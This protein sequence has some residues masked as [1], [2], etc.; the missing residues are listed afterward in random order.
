VGGEGVARG[1]LGRPRLTAE[2]FVP[3]PF[4]AAAAGARLYRTGDRVRWT[5]DGVLEFLG[6]ADHQVKIRGFRVE[7]GEVEAALRNHP[8]VAECA[9]VVREDAPGDRRLVAYVVGGVETAELRDALRTRLPEYMVPSA[10]VALEALPLTPSGKVDRRALPQPERSGDEAGYVAPRTPVEEA[11]AGIWAEVLRLERVG[12]HDDFFSLGGH[13]LLIMR[14]VSRAREVFG[15]ELPVRTLFEAP[16]IDRLAR[17]FPEPSVHAAGR[18]A[19]PGARH[20][21]PVVDDLTDDELDRLLDGRFREPEH[22]G[23]VAG[24]SRGEKQALLREVMA[25]R[26]RRTRTEPTSFAQERL[27]FLDRL[28]PG[29]TSYNFPLAWRLGGALD[30]RALERALGEIVRRH[31]PLRTTFV[32]RDGVPVQVVAPFGGFSLPVRERFAEGEAEREAVARRWVAE[33]AA[34]PFDLEAGPLF[35]AELLRLAED[36][37]VLLISMHHVVTDEWSMGVLFR[38][39]AALYEAYREGRG[40]PLAELPAQYADF[41]VWQRE[42]WGESEARHLAYWRERLA[43]A[44]ALLELPIDHPRQLVQS[45]H[46]AY[47]RAELPAALLD[48]LRGLGQREGATLYMVLLAAFQLLLSKYSGSDDVVVGSSIAG[49]TRREVEEMIGFFVNTLVLRTDLSGDPGFRELLA[50]VRE[51]TLGAFEHQDVPFERL[52]A[53]LQPE[54]SLGHSPLFQVMFSLRDKDASGPGLAGLELRPVAV[55]MGTAKFD[56]NLIFVEQAGGLSAVLAYRT[57]LF[58]RSTVERMLGHLSR[59]LEQIA[60]NAELRLS[61]LRLLGEEERHRALVEWNATET[62]YPAGLCIHQLFEAQAERTPDAEAIIFEGARLTYAGLNARANRLAHHL[63]SL[64]VGPDA[65]VGICVERSLELVIGL[66]AL[67]KAGGAYVAL[68]PEHP[69]ERLRTILEDSRPAVLLADSSLAGRFAGTGVPVVAVDADTPLWAGWPETNPAGV[70]VGPEHLVYVI[71]TSGSTGKPKGVLN[72]HRNVVNRVSGIQERWRLEAGE[73]VLQNASLTFDVSAY[74]IFWPLMVGGRVV[75]M[76]PDGHR[77]PSYLV[78]TIRSHG[79]GTASF[80]PSML[81]LFLEH[82]EVESCESLVRVPCGGEALPVALVR[83]LHERLPRATLYNRYGPSEAA[84]AVTGP[85]RVTDEA[86]AS[87]PIGRPMPNAR[88]YLLDRTGEPVPVGVAGELCIGGAGVGRGYLGRSGLTAERFVPDPFGAE[89]GARLYRT[90]DLARWLPDGSIEFL[91]RNDFQ[92]KI[93]GFR[94]EPGE[95]EARLREHAAVREV[96][97]VA[98]EDTPGDTRLVAYYAGGAVEAAALRAHLS[99]RVPEYMVPAAWVRLDALPLTPSGKL[100]R[101]ALPAPE[102][103]AAAG[104]AF[105]APAGEVEETLARIWAEVLGVDRVGRWDHFF[106]LGGHSLLATRVVSRARTAFGVTLAVRAL[107]EAPTLEA[108]ARAVDTARAAGTQAQAAIPRVA[109]D[110]K[111]PLSFPQQRLWLMDRLHPGLPLYNIWAALRLRGVLD[112]DALAEALTALVRRHE[113]L[114]TVFG[115]E[116]GEPV[117]RILPAG[118]V[119]LPLRDLSALPEARGDAAMRERMQR[120]AE[121]PF[122]LQRGPLFRAELLRTGHDEHVLLLGMHHIVA[123]AWSKGILFRELSALY[124]AIREGRKA[125][126]PELAV[127]YADYSAWQRETLAGEWLAREVAWWR[128]Q[129]AGAPALLALPTDRP[130]PAVQSYRGALHPFTLSAPLAEALE[131]LALREGASLYMVLLAGFQVL[132]SRYGGQDEVVVGSPIDNRSRTELDGL[133]GFFV[134]TIALRADL[135]GDPGFREV[136]RRVRETTLDAYAHQEVPFEKLVE[137]LQPERSLG[138]NP[139]FQ[140]FFS[141]QNGSARELGLPGVEV[142]SLAVESSTSKFDLALFVAPHEGRLQGALQYA[143]DLFEPATVARIAAGLE[144]LLQAVAADPERPLSAIPLTTA[145]ERETILARWS[146]AGERFPVTGALHHRF[147]ARAA[148]HPDAPAVACDGASLTWGA[149]NARANRLA[150][151]L[152]AEGVAPES[153]VGLCAERSLDLVVG[154]LAILKAGGAYVPLDPAYPAERL[155]YMA[156]D[157]GLRVV[158]AQ[159]ALRDRVPD[160][161]GVVALEDVPL[162]EMSQ[163]PGVPVDPS[164]L[165]YVIY[166][167]G[168]TGRPK[169]VG[170]THGNVLRLFDSMQ[171]SFAFGER[172]VWTLFHSYAFDFSVWEIWGALLHGGRLV[173]V[174]FDVSRDPAAFRELLRRERVTVLNQTPSAFHALARADE[175]APEPLEHLRMVVFGGEALQYESLRGWLD[176]YGPRQPRLVNMYGITE[177]T[178]HVTWH[179]VTGAELRQ[180]HVGSGVGVPI[181]DLRAYVLDPTGSPAPV[182]IAGELYV[183]GA[184]LARGYLGRPELTARRFVPDP[185]SGDA[186]ARLYR[187]GDLARWKAD[188]TLEYLGRIDQQVKIR[189]HR[190]ELGEIESQLLAQPGVAAAAVIVRG[191]GADA[192]LVGYVVPSGEAPSPSALRDALRRRLPEY[193]VPAAFVALDRIPLTANGKLDRRA[194]PTPDASAAGADDA[195]A[196][197]ATPVAG[198][199]A[200]IWAEVL[201]LERVGVHDDFFELG[202]HSLRATQA[203]ARIREVF[204][205]EMPLR[206]LFEA[207]TVAELAERVEGLRR[208]GGRALPPVVAVDRDRPLPLSF[209]QERMWFLN[210]LQ[211]ETATYNHPVA[212]RLSGA[213]DVPALERALGEVVRRQQVL[214]T[215]LPEQDGRPVQVVTPFSGFVLPVEELSGIEEP[216]REA[217]AKRRLLAEASRPFDLSAG[218][219]FRARLLRLGEAEHVL[220]LLMHHVVTDGWSTGVLLRELSVLYEAYREGGESPLAEPAVQYADYAV[221]QREQLRGEVLEER[222][223]Y[224]RRQLSGAPELLELPTDRPRPAVQDNRGAYAR[225]ELP[226]VLVERLRGVCR[227]EGATLYMVL[228][229]GFQVLLSKYSGSEDVVVGSPIAGRTS[230]EVEELVGFFVNTLVLRTDL[231]GDPTVGEL[232]ARVREATLGAYEHQDVPFER[233]VE[234]LRPERSLSHTPLFQ[235]MF[236]LQN[237][238]SA[239]AG[240]GGLRTEGME[241]GLELAKFDLSLTLREHAGGI[242]GVLGYGTELFE[243]STIERMLGHLTRVLEQ[244]AGNAELRLSQVSLAG[245]EERRVV[246]EAW[247]GT[248]RSYAATPV[249]ALFAGHAR[250]APDAAALLHGGESVSYAALDR[251]ADA[252]ARRLRALGVG[253]E[254]RVGVCMD[255]TPEL[256]TA[257][258]GIWKAGGA[259]VP[260][261]PGYP[262]ER[263]GWIVADAALPVVVTAGSAGDALPEHAAALVRVEDVADDGPGG[264][265]EVPVWASTLAYVIYTSGST[266]RPKGVVVQHGSLA[267]LLAATRE[268]FG[269]GAG[270]VMPALASHAF[271]IWLFEA[272][273]PLSSGAAVRL[274][275]RE[276]VLDVPALLDEACDATLLHAVPAL[277][278]EIAQVERERPRLRRLRRAFVGGDRVPADLLAQMRIA[279]PG[280]ETHILY[281]PTEGTILASTHPVAADRSVEGHPI[282]S[283]LGNVRLYVCDAAGTPQPVG[284][285]GE[286]LIGGAGVARGYLGRP[287]LTADRFVPDPFSAHSGARLYRTG[288]RVRWRADGR[289]EFQ[290]RVDQQVK[291]RGFRIEPGEVEAVLGEHPAVRDCVVV[292]REDVPGELRLVAYL[293][294]EE[295][296]LA[297]VRE[298]LKA[299]VPE[300]MVPSAFV[301]LDRLPLTPN[302]KLDRRALPSPEPAA[303]AVCLPPRNDVETRVAEA[304]GEV[305]G[306]SGI[307]VHDNFFDLGGSSLLLYRV[308]SRLRELRADLRV[309]DLFRYTTIEALAAYLGAQA[310]SDT[311][312]LAQSRSRAEERRAARQRVVRGG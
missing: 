40:S 191:E 108:L 55:G 282:G 207:P 126:L 153:R 159:S 225:V 310:P 307:G 308:Y 118:P 214:R 187:S 257:V 204:G 34:R 124:G 49:R 235:V 209:G 264:A 160:G 184:G 201:R 5:A 196:A 97:V 289:L 276:R 71:Y 131:A 29:N 222:L 231:S 20:L 208:A 15:A 309:V 266:G 220:Q 237:T 296:D 290:G 136:L 58:E 294:A 72:V 154:V 88:A 194:L 122:D 42:Q 203:V 243:R 252:L 299:K 297:A 82:P 280:A 166:T 48:R 36:E 305:L 74:E 279:F 162:D 270:D 188:G 53:E 24:L 33:A 234:E 301:V 144:V 247:N 51:T 96:A 7:P 278:R 248:A 226:G 86:N 60:E 211:P 182:G 260:L 286:L 180:A 94:I 54:R 215:V 113:P 277:M 292:A 99:A 127:Q 145:E 12:V 156:E 75:M 169:G 45:S 100:D 26:T 147:E 78:E 87:A 66:L 197:P 70:G 44:P 8:G 262:A 56:L 30:A 115:E 107:F 250:R 199:L 43:G 206:A 178:V 32:D 241:A 198:V 274:A 192:A 242:R 245:A 150:R 106:A 114:R 98:R 23:A 212:L 47:E 167:S 61:E 41:A 101:K 267:N 3:D 224:W 89:P 193:M 251:R 174:P 129:L 304:W 273:L 90:G 102:G 149:L 110:G 170:V 186:G 22:A 132:L 253:P 272:L 85:V 171:S 120:W 14:V 200:G 28:Q 50:R 57:E 240:L 69:D 261:D 181:P 298:A 111:V 177:T 157:S 35:R 295:G 135:G 258:L 137:E 151:Q 4:A 2:R 10:V 228:L 233:L 249:H 281:G 300:H 16:T 143:T 239:P 18:S 128:A 52:V 205:V 213:L 189:G 165:A 21:G 283:P 39:L 65:R 130:R 221:W 163:D 219:L 269:V 92:V 13:S 259:Y 38:E 11:L 190:I 119:A 230:R 255:R 146:G 291:I 138:H 59:V 210:R 77:D 268:A 161:V 179:T 140:A 155:A 76:R 246:L 271:D 287:A 311:G 125:A 95:V 152:R 227:R 238:G 91:G 312:H 25:G 236:A 185:F 164:N 254:V 112:A 6:R 232:L 123:D 63:R 158:L 285:A 172:D 183:G 168:S 27:W 80:V 116:A 142:D 117:Q 121:A 288:D 284:V 216:E 62:E 68:D 105:E 176:R 81:Q 19:G 37:H 139:L 84:T 83:R 265:V 223:A 46:G 103:D 9:V 202:G 104:T 79:I 303:G 263:L 134:N 1:Y 302:G 31:E 109:R 17:V 173:V 175:L 195:F 293:A 229:A 306:R 217:E 218:P 141:L 64:G 148:A 275:S 133:I 93:R 73:S 244:I 67:L 256:L